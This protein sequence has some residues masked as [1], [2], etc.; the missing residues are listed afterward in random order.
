MPL[1]DKVRMT[2]LT[3]SSHPAVSEPFLT[4]SHKSTSHN[5]NIPLASRS[6]HF[7]RFQLRIPVGSICLNR[8]TK[9]EKM[10]ESTP[11]E[12]PNRE[13]WCRLL[14]LLHVVNLPACV[15]FFTFPQFPYEVHCSRFFL[16]NGGAAWVALCF[17]PSSLLLLR[18]S[19]AV[20][21]LGIPNRLLHRESAVNQYK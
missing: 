6:N 10:W 1:C 9:P 19:K 14:L 17:A 3:L 2:P 12:K 13:V 16:K 5:A 8:T 18:E 11:V 21:T 20:H 4:G 15:C 7:Q